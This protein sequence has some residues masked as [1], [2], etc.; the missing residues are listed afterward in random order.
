[1]EPTGFATDGRTFAVTRKLAEIRRKSA[2]LRKGA[3]SVVWSSDRTGDEPDAGVF[4][5]ER[6]GGDAGG[7]YALVVFNAHPE[8]ASA[9]GF[10]GNAMKVT[11]SPGTVLKDALGSGRTVTVGAGGDIVMDPPLDPQ[12]ALILLPQ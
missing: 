9:P 1:M 5:F 8:K 4:A 7:D 11:A 3:V 10:D 12:S 6:A 2:A